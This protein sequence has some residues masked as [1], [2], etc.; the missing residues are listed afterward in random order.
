MTFLLFQPPSRLPLPRFRAPFSR[1][2][3]SSSCKT[4]ATIRR[5]EEHHAS[6][7]WSRTHRSRV[8]SAAVAQPLVVITSTAVAQP[9]VAG[10]AAPALLHSIWPDP[11]SPVVQELRPA[12]SNEHPAQAQ[13]WPDQSARTGG[14]IEISSL[15]S[16]SSA[17]TEPSLHRQPLLCEISLSRSYAKSP[18][19]LPP[20]SSQKKRTVR[21][22]AARSLGVTKTVRFTGTGSSLFPSCPLPPVSSLPAVSSPSSLPPLESQPQTLFASDCD[23]GTSLVHGGTSLVHRV[24]AKN[25]LPSAVPLFPAATVVP[26]CCPCP[27]I[28][29]STFSRF[30]SRPNAKRTSLF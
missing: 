27:A 25:S 6:G 10:G 15:C 14:V 24:V 28:C 20:A 4:F 11:Q 5:R 30:H 21:S 17:E 9:S 29:N 7:R 1:P 16:P 18:C 23:C 19:P 8:F 3:L 26:F 2:P 12:A 22:R 13:Q